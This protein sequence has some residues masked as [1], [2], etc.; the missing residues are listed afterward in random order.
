WYAYFCFQAE[1]GIRDFH[2]T[3]VQ[4]CALPIYLSILLSRKHLDSF[5]QILAITFTNKAV[6]EM[7]ERIL[8]NLYEFSKEEI[9]EEPSS[10]FI[11][12]QEELQLDAVELHQ[13]ANRILHRILFNYAFFDILTIDKFNHRLIRTFAFDLKLSTNFEVSLDEKALLAEA[14]DN[15]IYKAGTDKDLTK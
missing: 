8:N 11:D 15:L 3:G 14:V 5:K 12:L 2:V 6:N 13:R 9:L 1:D 7:K 10:I 4:T